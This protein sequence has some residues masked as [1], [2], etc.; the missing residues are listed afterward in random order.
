MVFEENII[1]FEHMKHM[2]KKPNSQDE[3]GVG[4]RGGNH[5]LRTMDALR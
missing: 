5:R 1:C 2:K 4:E 3:C